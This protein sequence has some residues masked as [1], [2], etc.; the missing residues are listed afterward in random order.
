MVLLIVIFYRIT[1][2]LDRE[3]RRGERERELYSRRGS[4]EPDVSPKVY[5][6]GPKHGLR[7]F[8]VVVEFLW[9]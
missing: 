9:Y 6:V 4:T 7:F 3:N 8:V 2:E 5:V 1:M